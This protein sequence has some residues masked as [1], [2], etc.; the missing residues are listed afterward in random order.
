[1]N[2]VL[3][4]PLVLVLNRNWQPIDIRNPAEAFCQMIT[5]TATAL[6]LREDSSMVPTRWEEWKQLPV[7]EGDF[8]I[9]TIHGRIRIPTVLV[10][11]RFEKVPLRRPKLNFRNL[12]ER[13]G[14]RCQYTGRPLHPSEANIDH[15][16]PRS[17]QGKT[18]WENCVLADRSVNARKG[19]RTPVE[20]GLSLLRKPQAPREQPVTLFL[21]NIHGIP[22]WE[23]FLQT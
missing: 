11:S 19:N 21:R 4:Q 18:S 2:S 13:D 9:G 23:P 20:A 7:R 14:G 16:I 12:W 10:L 17:R 8:S 3:H 6:D 15:V 1:M 22:D 5:D